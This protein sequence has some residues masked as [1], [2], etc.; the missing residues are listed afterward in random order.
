[1]SDITLILDRR[2]LKVTMEDETV[3]VE[4]TVLEKFERIPLNMIEKLGAITS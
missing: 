1:M 4:R 2:V 3:R